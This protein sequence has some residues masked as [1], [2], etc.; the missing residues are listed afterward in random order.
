MVRC[1][2]RISESQSFARID[3]GIGHFSLCAARHWTGTHSSVHYSYSCIGND[4]RSNEKPYSAMLAAPGGFL[5]LCGARVSSQLPELRIK[6]SSYR[7]RTE[8]KF[9]LERRRE[10]RLLD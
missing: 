9:V 3:Q 7:R 1:R 6:K 4:A 2:K 5:R 10:H 8:W